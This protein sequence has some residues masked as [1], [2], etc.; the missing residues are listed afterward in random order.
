MKK[1][2]KSK[3][4]EEQPSNTALKVVRAGVQVSFSQLSVVK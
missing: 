3:S 4:I 1:F 2:V